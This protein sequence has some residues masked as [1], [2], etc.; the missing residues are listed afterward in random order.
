MA[1]A[2]FTR[3]TTSPRRSRRLPP[4][5]WVFPL[6]VFLVAG[7][8]TGLNLNGSSIGLLSGVG[9]DDPSLV[10]GTPRPVR[11]D[12][13]QV[14]T[15]VQV[16][17]VHKGFPVHAW[18]GLTD[19]DFR[20]T[21]LN[22][23]TASWVAVFEPHTW[24][25][26][27]LP[28]DR[29]FDARWWSYLV[30]PLV[31][32]FAL[33]MA[34][35]VS[36]TVSIAL[37]FVVAL[38][39]L[40]AWWTSPPPGLIVGY[41]CG[42][43]A[44]FL[45]A[46]GARSPRWRLAGGALAGAL[47]CAAF[48]VLYPPWFVAAGLVVTA[49]VAGCLRDRGIRFG[50]CLG[51][52]LVMLVISGTVMVGWAVQSRAALDAVVGTYYP[53][54]RV[55]VAGQGLASVLFSAPLNLAMSAPDVAFRS[56]LTMSQSEAAGP[57]LPLP[58]V[59]V[60]VAMVLVGAVATRRHA[61]SAA[62][63]VA[64]VKPSMPGNGSALE[65]R[66][67]TVIAVSAVVILELAWALIPLPGIVGTITLLNRVPG[68]R[69]SVG[70][71]LGVALLIGLVAGRLTW[72][73]R[74]WGAVALAA[75][76][77]LCVI[78]TA[79]SASGLLDP[80]TVWAATAIPAVLIVATCC[81]VL[82][83]HL[84][85]AVSV[86]V[87]VLLVAVV[88]VNWAVVNPLYRGLGPLQSGPLADEIRT[89]AQSE[90][91]TRWVSLAGD[92]PTS[93]IAASPSAVLSGVTYYPTPDVWERLAPTQEL[94]WNNYSKYIWQQSSAATPAVITQV[95]GTLNVL[96]IDLCSPQVDFLDIRYVVSTTG[97][98]L[99]SCLVKVTSF[100]DLGQSLTVSRRVS[101][102]GTT[103]PAP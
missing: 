33:L 1:D 59:V 15:P 68:I 34:M 53:G 103:Q 21:S 44:A 79:W 100:T 25:E 77:G 32:V 83:F 70:I 92:A 80:Q 69:C 12:E 40:G 41:L 13:W 43:G 22:P 96:E 82:A 38:S 95:H 26:F 91:P 81:V 31:G 54:Q 99:P 63:A 28:A 60:L 39:P 76:V 14:S 30:V 85:R 84:P 97:E 2:E 61:R 7:V 11:S 42:A 4:R 102:A 62:V 86:V 6:L 58:V 87:A 45:V 20:V 89:L 17:N 48:L 46:A 94:R 27:I 23:P 10:A 37:S 9:A 51:A 5:F 35:R 36:T 72:R 90:G 101:P 56:D 75:S 98:A 57:W 73:L 78:L 65:T 88:A 47:V 16:G 64:A 66:T 52:L 74:S 55:S 3:V 71:G 24:P 8:L 50:L 67:A 29:G 49:A 19:T 93:V 18:L